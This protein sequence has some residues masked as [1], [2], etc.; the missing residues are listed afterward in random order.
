MKILL[1]AP[2]KAESA[3][4]ITI[5]Y[6]HMMNYFNE[7]LSRGEVQIDSLSDEGIGVTHRL[8]FFMRLVNGYKSYAPFLKKLKK[9]L[10]ENK[11][12]EI[13][14]CTS[15]SYSLIKDI[16]SIQIAHKYSTK[17]VIHFHFGRIPS[18]MQSNNWERKMLQKVLT[19]A[20][21]VIV[22]DKSSLQALKDAGYNNAYYLPNPLAPIVEV[23]IE[24]LQSVERNNKYILFVGHVI[25][26]KGVEE[27]ILACSKIKGV[28]LVMFG[29]VNDE[30]KNKLVNLAGPNHSQWL[31]LR[32]QVPYDI[33]LEEMKK[34]GVF[35]LPTYTEGFPNV[36]I[37][38]MACGC[39]IITTPV[40]AI[41]DMLNINS[42]EP[43][44]VCV[45]VKDTME[46]TKAILDFMTD[47][48]YA[49][50]CGN[51]AYNRVRE[52]FTVDKVWQQ[53]LDIWEDVAQKH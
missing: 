52:L 38:S 8:S 2:L 10:E 6:H 53:I 49:N 43:C 36:I 44:G 12:D 27:L 42:G 30:Y 23:K 31:D 16:I 24:S 25:K 45:P 40:G 46:L 18:I 37:E 3:S 11:Y 22:I 34:C 4:G 33:V 5:W 20:D 9:T 51:R 48:F 50:L 17:A 29:T 21:G 28:Q 7:F 47:R 41:P 19:T 35:V 32:G 13:H 26:S 1:C 15:A 39:P 14:L